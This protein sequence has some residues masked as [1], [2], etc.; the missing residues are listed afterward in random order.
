MSKFFT[1]FVIKKKNK[2]TSHIFDPGKRMYRSIL[3]EK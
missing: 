3:Q 1:N 2:V